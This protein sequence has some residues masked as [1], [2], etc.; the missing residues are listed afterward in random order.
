MDGVL[1]RSWGTVT[2]MCLLCEHSEIEAAK[3]IRMRD[4]RKMDFST[5]RSENFNITVRRHVVLLILD[6]L[7]AIITA[8]KLIIVIPP[9]TH[10]I[11]IATVEASLKG[12]SLSLC[13]Q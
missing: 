4:I 10:R 9:G 1:S 13:L 12:V 2:D 3:K 5:N 11:D 7:R 6:P 8:S